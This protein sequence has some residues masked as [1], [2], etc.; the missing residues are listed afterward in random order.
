MDQ[1]DHPLDWWAWGGYSAV[2][3]EL[4]CS[5][6]QARH[7]V[8]AKLNEYFQRTGDSVWLP[9]G[10]AGFAKLRHAIMEGKVLDNDLR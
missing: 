5:H 4:R 9:H 6:A 7:K 2:M 1:V 10:N 3:R 8:R